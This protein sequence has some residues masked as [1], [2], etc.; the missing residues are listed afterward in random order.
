MKAT[1]RY[2]YQYTCL[3]YSLIQ[4]IVFL[5][6]VFAVIEEFQC[7]N[8]GSA[9]IVIIIMFVILYISA[10]IDK[11]LRGLK[12]EGFWVD[13]I[14]LTLIIPIKFVC[15]II[16]IVKLHIAMS[17][18]NENFGA[19]GNDNCCLSNYIFYYIFNSENVDPKNGRERRIETK[20]GREKREQRQAV[21]NEIIERMDREYKEADN[22]LRTYRRSDGRYNVHIVPLCSVDSKDLSTFSVQN[23]GYC[24]QRYITELYVDGKK[25]IHDVQHQNAIALSLKPG[26]YDFK[27]VVKGNVKSTTLTKDSKQGESSVNKTFELKNVYVG[28]QDVYLA[29]V[30]LFGTVYTEYTRFSTSTGKY[31]YDEFDSF[32]K[33]F[34][35]LQVSLSSLNSVCNYWMA[36]E[37]KMDECETQYKL[38][39]LYRN[40]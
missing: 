9:I 12:N 21:Y 14:L 4:F 20:R 3:A 13:C 31:T 36:Y 1:K 16:T 17:Y 37:A 11:L 33:R 25:I 27:V 7:G 10:I 8:N 22:F 38:Q 35:F 30:L 29:V 19:R 40:R 28:E 32:N 26:S 34:K 39:K 15:Q 2:I 23:N 18:G 6:S 5:A 24:G